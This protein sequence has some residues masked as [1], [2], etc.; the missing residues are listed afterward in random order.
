[1]RREALKALN[2]QPVRYGDEAAFRALSE[3]EKHL[4]QLQREQGEAWS[5]EKEWR[6]LGDVN[7]GRIPADDLLV[8]VAL[9]DEARVIH[10]D[11]GYPVT[12]SGITTEDAKRT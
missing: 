4:F 3:K 5:V 10:K 9:V 2:V 7:L 11:F 1:V 12:L 6:V 8:V